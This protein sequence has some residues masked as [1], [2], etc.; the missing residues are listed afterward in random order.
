VSDKWQGDEIRYW[1]LALKLFK[2][3]GKQEM[4]PF[5]GA[6]VSV[7]DR[8]EDEIKITP[9]YPD[10]SV[11]EQVATMLKLDGEARLYLEYAIR[12]AIRMQAW[13]KA[14]GSLPS[15]EQFLDRLKK[16]PYPPFAW[17]LSEMFSQVAP[18]NSM[19][20]TA[21]KAL[22]SKGLLPAARIEQNRAVLLPMLKLLAM[23]TDLAGRTDP[24]ASISSYYESKGER[25]D[26]W[27]RLHDV[28]ASKE[29]P[30][31]TH[32]LVADAAASHLAA[33]AIWED[34]LIITTNYDSLMEK[35]LDEKKVPYAVL[36]RNRYDGQVYTRFA[37]LSA[38][39]E[40]ELERLN[41]PCIPERCSLQTPR[42]IA[43]LYKMHGC[44]NKDLSERDDGLVISDTDYV[45]FISNIQTIIPSHVGSL[46]G[47]KHLLF[48]GYS[49]SDWN[50]RSLY[51]KII[52]R[53]AKSNRRD[54][55]VTRSLSRFEEVYFTKR[56]IIIVL[57]DLKSFIN[58]IRND[59]AKT[60][61]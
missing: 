27:D 39:E 23:T 10:D 51:E 42:H 40:K 46:L 37:N 45:D 43:V 15:R 8:R 52:M 33:S 60:T 36:R 59:L 35:A 14:N 34:Y 9:E 61:R 58:G 5:L 56:D 20:D 41:T 31:E 11:L 2:K 26:L 21:L 50:V 22:D 4:I 17:E 55:A 57:T 28:V 18:Y 29:T 3:D 13:E 6:G 47:T 19:E 54:Y 24:L 32:R 48:L 30:T 38:S 53:T 12:T 16:C 25:K 44:L 1:D 49:F 7:S